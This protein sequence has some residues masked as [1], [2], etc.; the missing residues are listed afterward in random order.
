MK[1]KRDNWPPPPL[2]GERDGVTVFARTLEEG[3]LQA[4]GRPHF[5]CLGDTL[6]TC[7]VLISLKNKMNI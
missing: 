4:N 3:R 1:Y 7:S 6:K 2:S 5:A